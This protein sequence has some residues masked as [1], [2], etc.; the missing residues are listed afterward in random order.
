MLG[1]AER[2][3]LQ[4][5]AR[6]AIARRSFEYFCERTDPAYIPGR[7]TK[8]LIEHLEAL[9]RGEIE[10]LMVSMPPRHSKTYHV[11]E[12]FPAWWLG[13]DPSA[14]MILAS[15]T[16][17]RARASSRK[18]RSLFGEPTWPF[19]ARLDPRSL[20]VDEWRTAAGGIV[21]AA[22]VGGSMTGFG[23][24]LLDIDDPIKD[25]AQANS[26]TYRESIWDWYTEVAKTRLM[27]GGRELLTNTR[28][29]EDDLSGRIL[30]SAGASKW[31]VLNLPALA[32]CPLCDATSCDHD[33]VDELGRKPG[34]SL[35]P[36]GGIPIPNPTLGEISTRGFSALYQGKPTPDDG[37]L[38]KRPWFA[39]RFRERPTLQ[40]AA[41]FID[42][43]WKEGV[44]NDRSAIGLW[45]FTGIEYPLIDA[46]AARV[47]Y[48]D[49]KAKVVDYY[50]RWRGIAPVFEV[51]VEDGASGIPIIQELSRTTSIPIVGVTVDNSKYTRAEAISAIPESGKVLL[52]DTE[53][54][55]GY[56]VSWVDEW[57]E[58]H[59]G[60]PGRKHDDWVDT[61]SG[62]LARLSAP[63]TTFTWG[64]MSVARW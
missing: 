10:K 16:I 20:A 31:T 42:G 43:A 33:V 60:F 13:H 25:R 62:A 63:G 52:P 15:Y 24:H 50:A 48:P 11:S 39:R 51:C 44:A 61:T 4:E 47:E 32:I 19:E 1:E 34:E 8:R 21:K 3:A 37:S 54:A 46:W 26:P 17:D 41:M 55:H 58:E 22:G 28:W 18:A 27:R 53:W 36:E 57:I 40:K 23:A 49:L 5:A 38:F 14:Q 7:H 45:G 2:A 29:H 9:Q 35:W 64:K 56:D 30:N 59:V 6:D 12:R